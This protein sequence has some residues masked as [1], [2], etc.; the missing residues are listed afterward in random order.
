MSG[1]DKARNQAQGILGK[2]K[3]GFGRL[4]GDRTIE[5]KGKGDQTKSD[6]KGAGEKVKDAFKK[7]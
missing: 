4:T 7:P 3:Q 6:L 5:N 1:T 2:V